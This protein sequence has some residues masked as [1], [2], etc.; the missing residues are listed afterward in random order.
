MITALLAL[1]ASTTFIVTFSIGI[2]IL[3]AIL[4]EYEKEGWATSTFSLGIALVLWNFKMDIWNYVSMNP[5]A[6]IGFAVSYVLIGIAWSFMK[7]RSYVKVVFDRAKTIKDEFIRKVGPITEETRAAFNR[8]INDAKFKDGN[9]Y[10]IS[11][12]SHDEFTA[13]ANKIAPQASDKKSVITSWISYWPVSLAGTLLNNP[14]RKFF[15][16]IYSNISGFY[17][18]ITNRYK[19]DAFG[20]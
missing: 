9:G 10:S 18:K 11:I 15:E 6:T 5:T 4:L 19:K 14:F 8:K 16:F 13:I 7:W 3:M 12:D 17:D 1:L 2:I 20:I